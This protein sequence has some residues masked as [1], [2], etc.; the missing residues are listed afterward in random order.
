MYKWVKWFT[1]ELTGKMWISEIRKMS[2][3]CQHIMQ[4]SG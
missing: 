1:V 4:P 2:L 3:Q